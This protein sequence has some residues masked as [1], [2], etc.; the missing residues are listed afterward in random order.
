M[1]PASMELY[2]PERK[3]NVKTNLAGMS[4]TVENIYTIV[5]KY[6]GKFPIQEVEFSYF[7]P[8][9]KR[10][11]T[12]KSQKLNVDVFEGPTLSVNNDNIIVSSNE[13]FK[14]IKTEKNFTRINKEKFSNSNTFFILLS[15]PILSLLSFII[16]YS[17]P[18]RRELNKNEKIKQIYKKIKKDLNNAEKSIGNK[19]EFYD[20]I[21][22]SIY[23]FLQIRFSI[24]TNKLNKES[25]TKQMI[26]EGISN[27]TI[28]IILKLVESCERA[29]Y[30]NSTDHEMTSD[31]NI[32]NKI[33]D[34]ILKNNK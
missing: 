29:R 8:K 24:E 14:F 15:F 20:L 28:E 34:E 2:E 25:I 12:I 1:V 5:P 16:F 19:D 23:N 18:K 6:Q 22:K 10:Y 13:S 17:L 21:E 11:R 31:L 9:E 7:D 27:K 33:F 26:S 32:A 4:G 3:E 30:S